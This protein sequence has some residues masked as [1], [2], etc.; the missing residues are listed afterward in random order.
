MIAIVLHVHHCITGTSLSFLSIFIIWLGKGQCCLC[1]TLQ[2]RYEWVKEFLP[3]QHNIDVAALSGGAILSGWTLGSA[4][5]A[6]KRHQNSPSES[7]QY[8]CCK[9]I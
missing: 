2:I 1:V 7:G 3:R 6:K 9:Q 5:G 4:Q 8:S